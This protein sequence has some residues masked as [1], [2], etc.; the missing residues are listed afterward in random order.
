MFDVEHVRGSHL[1]LELSLPHALVFQVPADNRIVFC[2]PQSATE[3][4]LGTTEH[5]H[6]LTDPIECSEA[7]VDYLLAVLNNHLDA[8]VGRDRIKATLSGVR[9]IAKTR[10]AALS[11]MS[12][13]SRD[14]EI[15]VTDSLINVFGGKWTSARHLGQ[16]VAALI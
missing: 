9:P 3:V 8:G 14:S 1:L 5:S 13:A 7:E 4:L 2:I 6:C 10:Q 15:E 16:K 12:T 11:N